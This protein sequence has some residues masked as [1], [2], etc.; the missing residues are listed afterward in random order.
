MVLYTYITGT[1]AYLPNDWKWPLS[2][3]LTEDGTYDHFR[4][5]DVLLLAR[6]HLGRGR[7]L[8]ERAERLGGRVQGA[9]V[10]EPERIVVDRDRGRRL[11][12]RMPERIERGRI[13]AIDGGSARRR[14]ARPVQVRVEVELTDGTVHAGGGRG[15]GR[16]RRRRLLHLRHAQIAERGRVRTVLQP[17][18][19]AQDAILCQHTERGMHLSRGRVRVAGLSHGT[20]S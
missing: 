3:E 2:E 5:F 11:R 8:A 6:G 10:A 15:S 9:R 4:D 19:D 16:G 14:R 20:L 1:A 12:A 18:T 13:V 7:A 17:D